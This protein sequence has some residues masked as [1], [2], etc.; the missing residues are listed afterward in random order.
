VSSAERLKTLKVPVVVQKFQKIAGR[1]TEVHIILPESYN[2]NITIDL[3][4]NRLEY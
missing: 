3:G 2:I 1:M 4:K